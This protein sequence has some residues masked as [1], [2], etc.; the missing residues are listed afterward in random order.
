ML[1]RWA[2]HKSIHRQWDST[3]LEL[4]Q[5]GINLILFDEVKSL[6]KNLSF[7]IIANINSDTQVKLYFHPL[8][9]EGG[10]V[11]EKMRGLDIL[12][13]SFNKIPIFYPKIV[14]SNLTPILYI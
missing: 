4:Y 8:N 1:V 6:V 14:C 9:F 13:I 7:R 11:L 10:M 3:L 12:K 5:T 2:R